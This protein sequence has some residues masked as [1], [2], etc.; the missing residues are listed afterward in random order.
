MDLNTSSLEHKMVD[1]LLNEKLEFAI[2]G[3]TGK[4]KAGV[5]DVCKLLTDESFCD[6]VTKPADT[7]QIDMSMTRELIVCYRYLHHNWRPFVEINVTNIIFSFILETEIEVLKNQ[8]CADSTIYDI[9]DDVLKKKES[10]ISK[11]YENL[12]R[13]G[14]AIGRDDIFDSRQVDEL[15]EKIFISD[16]RVEELCS[17]WLFYKNQIDNDNFFRQQDV[18]VFCYGCLVSISELF[19]RELRVY[20]CFTAMYQ[21]Y[22]NN[23]RG[24]GKVYISSEDDICPVNLF[25]IPD[26]INK[27]V[28]MLRHCGSWNLQDTEKKDNKRVNN[29]VYVVINNLKNL[30]E[31]FYFRCRYASFYLLAVTCDERER[32]RRFKKGFSNEVY[33]LNENLSLGKK[34]YKRWKKNPEGDFSEDEKIFLNFVKDDVIRTRCYGNGLAD[35]ILQDVVKC[36]EDADLFLKRNYREIDYNSDL[37]LIWA[38]GRMVT[39]IM[40]PGLLTPTKEER[41]MQIAMTAK[42][43]SGCLSRKVGAVITDSEYNIL[44]LGWNDAPCGAESCI[45]RNLFDLIRN[46]DRDAYSEY[47]CYNDEFREYLNKINSKITEDRK[48]NLNGLPFAFCFKD[49]YQ[50]ILAQKDQIYTRALH[51]EERAIVACKSD[52][53]KGG[54]LFTTS[55]PC[56]LCAKKIKEA[57]IKKIYYIEQYKGISQ[58]HIINIGKERTDYILFS[59]ATGIAY[60]RLYTPLMPYKD[61]LKA[62]GYEPA[63]IHKEA[64]YDV[65]IIDTKTIKEKVIITDEKLMGQECQEVQNVQ[66]GQEGQV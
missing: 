32:S 4:V 48:S 20:G 1:K 61:E 49:M 34:I 52:K 53:I 3:L 40:H 50:D 5:S 54:Y 31:A 28:K 65:K 9:I 66:E 35:F 22:G 42:L 41:C 25:C 15:F 27:F 36:I 19:E 12:K 56:E 47:E 60:V 43:N 62:Y 37:E 6:R 39:L 13:I 14:K 51:G 11:A 29:R 7:S 16:N 26:R 21:Q 46:Y 8:K 18:I 44:S 57:G 45:R 30:F 2:I 38:L 64:K 23:L 17:L 59:G 33:E 63:D 24:C 58:S 10:L 55:S